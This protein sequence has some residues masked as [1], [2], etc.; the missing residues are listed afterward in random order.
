[1]KRNHKILVHKHFLTHHMNTFHTCSVLFSTEAIKMFMIKSGKQFV[2][3][4]RKKI[5]L[6]VSTFCAITIIITII[7]FIAIL[8]SAKYRWKWV[9]IFRVLILIHPVLS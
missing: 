2:C 3:V 6:V 5:V 4:Y 9:S 8:V 7:I 1:M